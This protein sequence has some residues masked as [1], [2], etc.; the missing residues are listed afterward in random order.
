MSKLIHALI[1]VLCFAPCAIADGPITIDDVRKMRRAKKSH[2]QI[3]AIAVERGVGFDIDRK[4]ERFLRE[5]GFRR[6]QVEKLQETRATYLKKLE[7]ARKAKEEEEKKK[8]KPQFVPIPQRDPAAE[9]AAR[10][11]PFG[12]RK[13]DAWQNAFAA[14]M[15]RI[16]R[17]SNLNLPKA[18]AD[19][20][21]LFAPKTILPKYLADIKKLEQ[22]IKKKFGE[23]LRAGPDKRSANIFLVPSEY[24]YAAFIKTLFKE[25]EKDG[26]RFQN[27]NFLEMVLETK[28][29]ILSGMCVVMIEGL[30]E[31]TIHHYVAYDTGYLFMDQVC[32]GR[33]PVAL[34]TGF[35][36]VCEVMLLNR[37]SVTL[38]SYGNDP[39]DNGGNPWIGMVKDSFA[40]GAIKSIAQILKYKSSSMQMTNFAESWS[41][42]SF[43]A[44][45]AAR[46][47][48]MVRSIRDNKGPLPSITKSY[49]AEEAELLKQWKDHVNAQ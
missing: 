2:A 10:S 30:T 34:V 28:A 13:S 3:V 14:R 26:V 39:G 31:D 9:A 32:E 37:P 38:I 21:T 25:Y 45:H 5:M 42:T 4:I 24:E 35:G 23:P 44:Q 16:N 11:A 20:I 41:L 8:Q 22:M 43:L 36:N 7:D 27:P 48:N 12:P 49:G 29:F 1:V 15:D 33:A 19:Q 47:T 6:D 46:F 40:N 17:N 18:S